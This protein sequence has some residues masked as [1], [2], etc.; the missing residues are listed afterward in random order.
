M[1]VP[2]M[3]S[4][5][6]IFASLVICL[7]YVVAFG[8]LQ[9][10]V[11]IQQ[12]AS[13]SF[14]PSVFEMP[15]NG[16][17]WQVL[18]PAGATIGTSASPN[19]WTVTY[20]S[21][22][23]LITVGVPGTA[24]ISSGYK[25]R[26]FTGQFPPRAGLFAVTAGQTN[27]PPSPPT[28]LAASGLDQ[29][30]QLNW[31][32]SPTA[33]SYTVRRATTA[34]GTS[35]VVTSGLT[36]L[37]YIDNTVT[38]GTT[39]YYTITATNAFGTSGPSNEASATPVDL[40]PRFDVS[41]I[42]ET[43]AHSVTVSVL[44]RNARSQ[45]STGS[46]TIDGVTYPQRINVGYYLC[47]DSSLNDPLVVP[48]G[49]TLISRSVPTQGGGG[50]TYS[51]NG[52]LV[53]S[54]SEVFTFQTG[55]TGGA[56]RVFLLMES[57]TQIFR[58]GQ[59]ETTIYFQ[60]LP[61]IE[62]YNIVRLNADAVSVGSRLSYGQPNLE[63]ALPGDANADL[64]N[65]SFLNWDY[66]G[67]LFIGNV[68]LSSGD[69]SGRSRIQAY[70]PNIPTFTE[71]IWS[72]FTVVYLGVGGSFTNIPTYTLSVPSATDPN[73]NLLINQAVWSNAWNLGNAAPRSDL[74]LDSS[75]PP[76]EYACFQNPGLSP[77]MI[78][79]LKNEAADVTSGIAYWRYFANVPYAQRSGLI[80]VSDAQPRVW[81]VDRTSRVPSL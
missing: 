59:W 33:D 78:L 7:L 43:R 41:K 54:N 71:P 25:A 28:N 6:R 21:S 61:Q 38:N 74:T 65:P 56:A 53:Q 62:T 11:Q 18:S 9:G 72:A 76:G 77:R 46:T 8:R 58:N 1:K 20:S 30:V 34:G 37:A 36:S 66:K 27:A 10:M 16:N 42:N 31:S 80:T 52:L 35:T 70:I 24:G 29:A 23:N 68:P 22:T 3:N 48:Q 47:T 15:T 55:T 32:A 19:G 39:Y 4:V 40:S 81:V 73:L 79:H 45:V 14:T 69:L 5:T 75:I 60:T 51:M 64:R 57:V 17:S 49:A 26:I 13:G 63:G 44:V 50:T 12:G 67:G 2:P